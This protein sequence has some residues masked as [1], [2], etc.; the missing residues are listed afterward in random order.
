MRTLRKGHTLIELLAAFGVI[1]V[2][3]ALLLPAIQQSRESARRINCQN[4]LRQIGVALATYHEAFE[5]FPPGSVNPTGP[6]R[7]EPKGYHVSW[8]VQILPHLGFQNTFSKI[9]FSQSVYSQQNKEW[10]IENHLSQV[11]EC[12]SA[13]ANSSNA[14]SYAGVHHHIEAPIDENNTGVLF[15]NS[16]IC[17]E[18]IIDGDS[19]TMLVGERLI[20]RNEKLSWMSGTS[21]TLRCAT[22]FETVDDIY[23]SRALSVPVPGSSEPEHTTNGKIDPLLVTGG[24]GSFHAKGV[25]TVFCDGGVRTLDFGVDKKVL[26][27][28]ANRA[29]EQYVRDF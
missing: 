13:I 21:V 15:L 22:D 6:I 3:I 27:L 17:R 9:D 8:I 5:V 4:N 11:L 24:F 20:A 10:E 26:Q 2:L 1:L 16:S 29:D 14:S 28:L 19:H 18:D 7:S 12:P 23:N 25:Q